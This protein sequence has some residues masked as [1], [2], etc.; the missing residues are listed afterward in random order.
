VSLKKNEDENQDEQQPGADEAAE[1]EAAAAEDG[2][3]AAD[4]ATAAVALGLVG[5]VTGEGMLRWMHSQLVVAGAGGAGKS[6]CVAALAGRTFD[7]DRA[8]TVSGC[9]R[10]NAVTQL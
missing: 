7:P 4:R 6:S 10:C 2:V 8:S 5:R 9:H 3:A 1:D